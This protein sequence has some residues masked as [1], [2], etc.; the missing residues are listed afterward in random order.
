MLVSKKEKKKKKND[1][2]VIDNI[3]SDSLIKIIKISIDVEDEAH[4]TSSLNHFSS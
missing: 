2:T 4:V 1:I 3:W